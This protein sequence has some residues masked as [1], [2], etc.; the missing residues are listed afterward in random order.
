MRYA[1][2][3]ALGVLAATFCC[4]SALAQQMYQPYILNEARVSSPSA[5][6]EQSVGFYASETYNSNVAQSDAAL[7]ASRGLTLSDEITEIGLNTTVIQTLGRQRFFVHGDFGYQWYAH[8]HVLDVATADFNG[9]DTI[10]FGQCSATIEGDYFRGH[11]DDPIVPATAVSNVRTT[12]S[13]EGAANCNRPYGLNPNVSV[14]ERWNT[15]SAPIYR[16]ANSRVFTVTGGLDFRTPLLGSLG[17]WGEYDN[18]RYD[19]VFVL[20]EGVPGRDEFQVFTGGLKYSKQFTPNLA[21]QAVVTYTN[22]QSNADHANDYSGLTYAFTLDYTVAPKFFANAYVTREVLPSDLPFETYAVVSDYH[23]VGNYK[24]SSRLRLQLE[25]W[26]DHY[27]YRGTTTLPLPFLNAVLDSQT[28]YQVQ[29]DVRFMFNNF[30][31]IE[32][33]VGERHR[34]SSFGPLDYWATIVGLKIRA[35]F[36]HM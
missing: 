3:S 22:T 30:A 25:G 14:S 36:G 31:S 4:G 18:I 34:D 32:G 8:N 1:K 26:I 11:S 5:V 19:D 35:D 23:L 29:G 7:A 15:N 27:E 20:V 28:V 33:F 6:D 12:G 2:V 16:E 10:A 21:G 13:I 9:G 17:V 24:A